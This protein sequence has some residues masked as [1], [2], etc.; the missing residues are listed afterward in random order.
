[1]F[2]YAHNDGWWFTRRRKMPQNAFVSCCVFLRNNFL[3]P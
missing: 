3:C 2:R 1:L